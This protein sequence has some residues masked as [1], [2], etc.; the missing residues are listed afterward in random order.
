EGKFGD[1]S[2]H[3]LWSDGLS[4]LAFGFR[5]SP[6]HQDQSFKFGF[7]LRDKSVVRLAVIRVLHADRLRLCFSFQG[8]VQR[9]VEFA[10]QHLFCFAKRESWPTR[11]TFSKLSR[12]LR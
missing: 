2:V 8:R 12:R 6:Q 7:S 3:V 4:S 5:R 11:E 9:H 1:E 10:I